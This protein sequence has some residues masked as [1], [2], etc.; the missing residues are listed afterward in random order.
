MIANVDQEFRP[1]W[2]V[3]LPIKGG[4]EMK[5]RLGRT[6]DVKVLAMKFAVDTLHS[7]LA[8]PEVKRVVVVTADRSL[9]ANLAEETADRVSTFADPGGGLNNA[10][11]AA[12]DQACENQ[13]L[14]VIPGDMPLLDPTELAQ[15]LQ[16]ARAY[17][18]GFVRDKNGDGTTLLTALV[19]AD[20]LP[21]YG[22]GSAETH[23]LDGAVEL[24]APHSIRFD[25][26]TMED[27]A[28]MIRGPQ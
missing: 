1:G 15:V 8:C 4:G 5:T 22:A 13:L 17:P 23:L 19:A 11:V 20:L 3:I 21:N 14:V 10:I 12:R 7:V 24:S 18:R 9:L 27:L 2:C 26:D 16:S 28:E 6:E 25:V